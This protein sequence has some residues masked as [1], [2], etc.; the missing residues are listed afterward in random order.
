[1]AGR[2]RTLNIPIYDTQVAPDGAVLDGDDVI[3]VDAFD[4]APSFQ[5]RIRAGVNDGAAAFG[6]RVREAR[7]NGARDAFFGQRADAAKEAGGDADPRVRQRQEARAR[8]RAAAFLQGEQARDARES[9]AEQEQIARDAKTDPLAKLRLD[10][11]QAGATYME[12]LRRSGVLGAGESVA[13]QRKQL[14]D[15][16][17]IYAS[18]MVLQC[19]APLKQGLSGE[20]VVSTLGMAAS[21]W[22]LSPNFRIQVGN[23]ADQIGESI[24]SKI[25][26]REGKKD[27][28]ARSRF[29]QL[30]AQGKDDKLE[31]RWRRR[32]NRIKHAERGHRLPFTAQSAAM[33]EVAL[34]EAAYA[35]MRR[36]GADVTAIKDRYDTALSALYGYIDDDGIPREDVSR[37]MRV[38][39]GQRLSKEPGLANVFAETGHG[40]FVKDEPREV[41]IDGT[42]ETRVVWTGDFVDA[43]HNR[44]IS[45]GSFRVRPPMNVDDHRIV[46]A[47]TLRR[48][49]TSASSVAQVN[50]ILSQ[51]VVAASV[52]QHPDVIDMVEDPAARRRFGRAKTMFVSMSDDGLSA[53]D[54]H[55][56]Y[57]AAYVDAVERMQ[58]EKPELGAA[59]VAQYGENWREKV[60]EDIARFNEMGAAAERAKA[61]DAAEPDQHFSTTAGAHRFPDPFDAQ[62]GREDIVDADVVEPD[63]DSAERTA[64]RASSGKARQSQRASDQQSG[65]T[66][67][68][69]VRPGARSLDEP[70]YD[71]ELLED[72][73][74]NSEVLD[75]EIVEDLELEA[76]DMRRAIQ[77]GTKSTSAAASDRGPTTT[78]KVRRARVN[79]SYNEADTGRITGIGSD[80]AQPLQDPDFELG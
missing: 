46:A 50:D 75:V 49:M 16:H 56:V 8:R 18:M 63:V 67:P 11:I 19:V 37:S 74:A 6:A 80:D 14:S 52:A 60:A 58:E 47:D 61:R 73:T 21:M 71:A 33:T 78:A 23:F 54:Q 55:F 38:V 28:K 70:V 30:A 39:V 25:D 36:P 57:S 42:T 2:Q 34:A 31:S 9:K 26:E 3:D 24:R 1:M 27:D 4:D 76:G 20:N 29:E 69:G 66:F 45:S 7:I 22:L 5:E 65:R 62:P 48:E 72:G 10:T 32:L 40:R 77:A 15:L 51:Y 17:Q 53:A 43:D 13:S 41:F 44:T 35:D 12:S 64:H 68:M 59:W 79:Q